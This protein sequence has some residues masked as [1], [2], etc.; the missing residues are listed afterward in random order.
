MFLDTWGNNFLISLLLCMIPCLFFFLYLIS[1]C[2]FKCL[3]FSAFTEGRIHSFIRNMLN[4]IHWI[5]PLYL[6]VELNLYNHLE[7]ISE[8]CIVLWDILSQNANILRIFRIVSYGFKQRN[9][10][11]CKQAVQ[12]RKF[13]KG[14]YFVR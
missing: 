6:E 4:K 10:H 12:H 13:S 11:L 5:Q 14:K 8:Y 7:W 3:R 2:T 1:V 9:I